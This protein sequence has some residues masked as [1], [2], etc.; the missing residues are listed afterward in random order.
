[1]QRPLPAAT[2]VRGQIRRQQ[3]P[4]AGRAVLSRAPT[5][6]GK[7]GGG[8]P[9]QRGKRVRSAEQ[10]GEAEGRGSVALG[11][12]LPGGLGITMVMSGQGWVR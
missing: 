5:S 10:G 9:G 8:T 2:R 1:M 7:S 6:N 12:A 3:R 11:Q 4:G